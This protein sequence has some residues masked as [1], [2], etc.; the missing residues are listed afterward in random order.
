MLLV[1]SACP[2]PRQLRCDSMPTTGNSAIKRLH[3]KSSR[4]TDHL[5]STYL[6]CQFTHSCSTCDD[7]SW[8]ALCL[9]PVTMVLSVAFSFLLTKSTIY[10]GNSSRQATRK[11][12]SFRLIRRRSWSPVSRSSFAL[13]LRRSFSSLSKSP[14][15]LP[16]PKLL[17]TPD[18]IDEERV[19]WYEHRNFYPAKPGDILD[20]RFQI[21]VKVGWGS[22]STVWFARD[23]RK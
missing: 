22:S 16:P 11:M 20:D 7:S 1:L 12:W 9:D 18:L 8:S 23:M 14:F 4:M 21:L 5:K 3:R 13:P 17:S 19:P 15:T 2:G 10:S 6:V